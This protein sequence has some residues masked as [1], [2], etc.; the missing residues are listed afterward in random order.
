MHILLRQGMLWRHLAHTA[1]YLHNLVLEACSNVGLCPSVYSEFPNE[2]YI[3]KIRS[4]QEPQC[5]YRIQCTTQ[6]C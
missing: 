5:L 4:M 6:Q 1:M 2:Q 3:Q